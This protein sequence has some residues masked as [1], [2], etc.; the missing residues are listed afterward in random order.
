M[1]IV[2]NTETNETAAPAEDKMAESLAHYVNRDGVV[3]ASV[4]PN[5]ATLLLYT[6][7]QIVIS[8]TRAELEAFE[9]S[10]VNDVFSNFCSLPPQSKLITKI[11]EGYA[12]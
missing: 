6:G 9:Q 2:F 11:K 5:T 8:A 1:R 7:A 10:L 4:G 3:L 12:H